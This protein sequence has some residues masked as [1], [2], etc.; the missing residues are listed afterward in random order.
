M[1]CG[2]GSTG[3]W[4]EQRVKSVFLW[5]ESDW[6]NVNRVQCHHQNCDQSQKMAA[7]MYDSALSSWLT[8]LAKSK[9]KREEVKLSWPTPAYKKRIY[10]VLFWTYIV[11]KPCNEIQNQIQK[12]ISKFNFELKSECLQ[13]VRPPHDFF[14]DT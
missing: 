8:E 5:N 7:A 11:V 1:V 10:K 14:L 12:K 13:L 4:R 3:D 2:L 9:F 6:W